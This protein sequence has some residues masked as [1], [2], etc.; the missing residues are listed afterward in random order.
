[1]KTMNGTI[2]ADYKVKEGKL[3]RCVLNINQG[4]IQSVKITGDFFMYPEEGIEKLENMLTDL[5]Y[6]EGQ[7]KSK[8]LEFFNSNIQVVGANAEDFVT[9]LLKAN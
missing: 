8:I 2:S 7:L 6:N 3:L 9:L 1:M 4:I 5:Q